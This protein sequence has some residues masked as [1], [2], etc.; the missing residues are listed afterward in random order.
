MRDEFRAAAFAAE[1][2]LPAVMLSARLAGGGVDGHAADRVAG[3]TFR[4]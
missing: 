1:M 2:E 3:D 4:R